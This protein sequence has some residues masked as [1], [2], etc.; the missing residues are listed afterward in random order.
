MLDPKGLLL[1]FFHILPIMIALG[2]N[3]F[4]VFILSPI[5]KDTLDVALQ[6]KLI[7]RVI[8]K[9]HPLE[10]LC[11]GVS[12]MTGAW[13][14]TRYK[15]ASGIHFF[16]EYG[17]SLGIKLGFV[18]VLLM[19]AC[20]KFFG[21]GTGL[22]YIVEEGDAEAKA[23]LPKK[24]KTLQNLTWLTILFSIATI[25]SGLYLSKP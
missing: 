7:A 14:I 2:G 5:V 9:F 19:V 25:L 6:Q 4:V 12:L 11:Y 8:R 15:I 21:V 18:F 3:F 16:S 22:V 23:E 13:L 20:G 10:L 1:I 24:M 17:T